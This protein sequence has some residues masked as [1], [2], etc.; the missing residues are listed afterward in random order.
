MAPSG[1]APLVTN[2]PA[3]TFQ[4]TQGVFV[5]GKVPNTADVILT[6]KTSNIETLLEEIFSRN[7]AHGT[8]GDKATR[9][10]HC[11]PGACKQAIYV[12]FDR[13]TKAYDSY[14]LLMRRRRRRHGRNM[15]L[16][17]LR[18]ISNDDALHG[19]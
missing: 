8:W 7:Y 5:L 9:S 18:G 3:P 16:V 19:D 15:L 2:L 6:L 11:Q 4:R 1:S 14:G 13:H 10:V 17:I 12:Q